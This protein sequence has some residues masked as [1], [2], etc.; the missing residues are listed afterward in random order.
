MMNTRP[1]RMALAVHTGR[2]QRSDIVNFARQSSLY[3]VIYKCRSMSAD[4]SCLG[5]NEQA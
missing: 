4:V 1:A 5:L 3:I 2:R